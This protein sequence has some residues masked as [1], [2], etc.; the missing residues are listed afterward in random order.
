VL[1]ICFFTFY[2]Y[3]NIFA[4]KILFLYNNNNLEE[5]TYSYSADNKAGKVRHKGAKQ[6]M[7]YFFYFCRAKIN[8]NG[9]KCGF[10]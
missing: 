10:R 9:I 5:K 6:G 2:F 4:D 1:S 7:P 8:G 3:Y